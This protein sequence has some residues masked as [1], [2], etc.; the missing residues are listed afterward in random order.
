MGMFESII[1]FHHIIS[2]EDKQSLLFANRVIYTEW[3][4]KFDVKF[5]EVV[6]MALLLF[7]L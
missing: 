7:E 2:Y 1:A 4:F 6:S 5:A 3:Y